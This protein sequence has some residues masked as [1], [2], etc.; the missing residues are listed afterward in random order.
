MLPNTI[1]TDNEAPECG[2]ADKIRAMICSI[3]ESS[4]EEDCKAIL[5][6]IERV[7]SR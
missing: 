3:I 2:D 1:H 6:I 4:T 7:V 5:T